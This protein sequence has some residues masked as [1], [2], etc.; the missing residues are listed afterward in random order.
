M[1]PHDFIK[2]AFEERVEGIKRLAEGKFGPEALIGFTRHNAA[3]ITCGKAGINGSIK[4]IGFIHRQEYLPEALEK[5]RE[6]LQRPYDSKRALKFLLDEIYV[7]EKIDFSK[8]VSLE[9]ARKHTWENLRTGR[10]EAT[11]LFFTPPSTSY[12][13]RCEVE[14]HE[15]GPVWEFVNA[16]HDT[17]HRPKEPRDWTKTPAY[18]FKIREIYDNGEKAMG[19]RVYP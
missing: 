9:L 13:V 15:S 5:L 19:V 10:K 14:I 17:F 6:E 11:I 18:L 1:I 4:G 16:V 3:V 7:R 12:E 8:L 2:Y